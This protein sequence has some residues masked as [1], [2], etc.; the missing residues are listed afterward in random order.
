MKFFSLL[1]VSGLVG[2]LSPPRRSFVYP[3]SP[4]VKATF[5]KEGRLVLVGA[6]S[7]T[8]ALF[9]SRTA[10]LVGEFSGHQQPVGDLDSWLDRDTVVSG[11][12]GGNVLFWRSATQGVLQR[13]RLP[14]PVRQVRVRPRSNQAAIAG[15]RLV[16]LV[17]PKNTRQLITDG[18][19]GS[20]DISS[21]AFSPDGLYLAVGYTNG[22]I[23]VNNLANGQQKRLKGSTGPVRDMAVRHDS[24]L[25]VTG[26]PVLT[27][28]HRQP[29]GWNKRAMTLSR[30]L[31]SLALTG[32]TVTLG[33]Q[34]GELTRFSLLSQQ[35]QPVATSDA[36][37]RSIRL[38]PYEGLLLTTFDTQ[39]PKTW[40]L[41]DSPASQP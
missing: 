1:L 11:D 15:K 33:A 14:T 31:T 30:P 36:P 3:T 12:A 4:A 38:H 18:A 28:W 32:S 22:S 16:W 20:A 29:G 21:I 8:I 7:G 9:H 23:V 13:M 10:L 6:Q 39:T 5:S 25:A 27:L 34:T 26:S 35:E 17:D 41:A 24:L 40:R 2:W 37:P 19:F